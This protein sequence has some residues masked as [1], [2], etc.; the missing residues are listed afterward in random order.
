MKKKTVVLIVLCLFL[1]FLFVSLASAAC[2]PGDKAQVL[3]KGKWYP[4]TVKEAKGT[5]C[6][7]HYEGYN[8]SWDEWVGPERI[9]LAGQAASAADFNEGDAVR[10]LWKGKWYD[11]HVLKTKGNQYFIH[12]DG[13]N[14]SWD[15]WVGPKR[16]KAK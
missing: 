7:I 4:A 13:Y 1:S 6:F 9:K 2:Q 14:N 12:Y 10:V 3:W 11:A 16:I 5:Q 8:N 15:E